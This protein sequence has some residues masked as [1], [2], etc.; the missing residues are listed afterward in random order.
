LPFGI[1]FGGT[2]GWLGWLGLH[3]VFL[4]G[5]RNRVVVVVNWARNY[6]RWDRDNRVILSDPE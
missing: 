1:R 6:L 3:L 4:I 2:L 5:L